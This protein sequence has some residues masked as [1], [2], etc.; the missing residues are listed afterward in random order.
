MEAKFEDCLREDSSSSAGEYG[1]EEV[2]CSAVEHL[3]GSNGSVP[4]SMFMA[5]K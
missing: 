3:R 2:L 1:N 4:W 5:V